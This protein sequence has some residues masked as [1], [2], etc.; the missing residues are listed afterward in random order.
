MSD[1]IVFQYPPPVP[2]RRFRVERHTT[3]EPLVIEAAMV[4]AV[5]GEWVSVRRPGSWPN[6]SPRRTCGGRVAGSP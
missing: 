4:E 1:G 2:M 6:G 5:N 3:T